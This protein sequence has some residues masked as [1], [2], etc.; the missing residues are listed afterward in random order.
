MTS[1]NAPSDC[2]E[3]LFDSGQLDLQLQQRL[4]VGAGGGPR[5]NKPPP[6]PHFQPQSGYHYP[7]PPGPPPAAPSNQGN[8]MF[9]CP[10]PPINHQQ[11]YQSA[12]RVQ[13]RPLHS[14]QQLPPQR[15]TILARPAAPRQPQPQPQPRPQLQEQSRNF[16]PV[17]PAPS[18][19]ESTPA[20]PQVQV[21][22]LHPYNLQQVNDFR[23]WKISLFFLL[24][25]HH[26][27]QF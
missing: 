14:Q 7:P 22:F 25:M 17:P 9:T 20:R 16:H 4:N 23:Q 26:L 6:Q 5:F 2:W 27:C 13:E 18:Q 3:D 8:P 15:M 12:M 1:A 11:G 10:P 19:P 21:T 24:L